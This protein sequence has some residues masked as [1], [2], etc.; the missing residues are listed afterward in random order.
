MGALMPW[1]SLTT[2]LQELPTD[3]DSPD[4]LHFPEDIRGGAV[5]DGPVSPPAPRLLVEKWSTP[6][7]SDIRSKVLL[8]P[9][10]CME[11]TLMS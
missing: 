10:P 7:Q 4:S 8:T 2:F 1:L 11:A 6:S 5:V 3:A 9:A